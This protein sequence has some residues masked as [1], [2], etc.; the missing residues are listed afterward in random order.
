MGI[1]R[2]TAYAIASRDDLVISHG[3]P[4]KNNGKYVGWIT[5]GEDDRYRSL[6]NTEAIYDTP[7]EAD[8]FSKNYKLYWDK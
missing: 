2:I 4:S 8:W 3:G 1:S 5:L 6:V 7:E